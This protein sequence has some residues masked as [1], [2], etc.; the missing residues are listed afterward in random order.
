MGDT[1]DIE[2]GIHTNTCGRGDE[3]TTSAS[4]D[5]DNPIIIHLQMQQ[6]WCL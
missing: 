3:P 6:H 5:S 2:S 4:I 1:V